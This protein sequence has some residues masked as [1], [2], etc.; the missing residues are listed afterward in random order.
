M[1]HESSVLDQ[2]D[3]NLS[4]AEILD[5]AIEFERTAVAF[6]SAL[7]P[8]VGPRLRGLV[9]ELAEEEEHHYLRFKMLQDDPAMLIQLTQR[10]IPPSSHQRFS[11]AIALPELGA[12]PTDREVLQYAIDREQ[13]AADQYG[14]LAAQLAPGPLRSLLE[15]LA[16]EELKHKQ[17][18]EGIYAQLV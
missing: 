7:I 5:M 2:L 16:Y 14:A 6:F 17:A 11:A 3:S 13:S 9:E 8:K 1:E 12:N 4:V 10:V 15:L 18:L